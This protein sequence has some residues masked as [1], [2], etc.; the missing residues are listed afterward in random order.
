MARL[1]VNKSKITGGFWQ[2]WQRTNAENAIFHQWE[3]LEAS[4]CIDNFRI[5]AK[6]KA[7]FRQGWYFADSDAYKWLEAASAV[8]PGYPNPR[9]SKRVEAFISLIQC[10]QD[11]DGYLYTYNQIHFPGTRWVNLQIEH[12]LYCH[13]HLIEA[14]VTHAECL[15]EDALLAVSRK[16]AD[17]IAAD[18]MDKG[19]RWT[20]GHEEIEIALLRLYEATGKPEYLEMGRAFIERRG[21]M[22]CFAPAMLRNFINNNRRVGRVEGEKAAYQEA[23]PDQRV[24]PLPP[25]NEAKQPSGIG[26]RFMWNALSGKL[27]QQHRPLERQT[28]PVGHAVRFAYLKTAAAMLDRI[29]GEPRYLPSL[30]AAWAHMTGR[31]MYLTGGIG[32]L[33]AIEGFG[34]DFELDPEFA[35]AETCAALG[36]LFWN[37][38]MSQLTGKAQYSDL[39]EWQLYNAALVGMGLDGKS[40]FYNNPLVARGGIQRRDWYEVPC[41]P[42]NLSR[43]FARLG[44]AILNAQP[45]E[46]GIE[47]YI[48]SEH[49]L[50]GLGLS[51]S[52]ESGFP[53]HGQVVLQIQKAP[54]DPLTLK[55]RRP[56][57]AADLRIDLN[58][59][60]VKRI[61]QAPPETLDP[62]RASWI[63][64]RRGWETGDRL[65]L[66]FA[67]PVRVLKTDARVKATRGK[68]ALACGPLVYCLESVDRPGLDLFNVR[69]N[70]SSLK[71]HFD[72][73]LL[74]G[75]QVIEG[76]TV[77]GEKVRFIP[78][79]LWGNRGRSSM[80]VFVEIGEA[81]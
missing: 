25:G 61:Q 47:Q 17:R 15:G 73:D 35:Y 28:K 32:S 54:S 81:F 4:G 27:F 72:P 57:W 23:H 2:G 50:E 10:A 6:G 59:E 31:K 49:V 21:R 43:T 34:R 36:S 68:A 79:H 41:C 38:E 48:S 3:Q 70:P 16:A 19:P 71:A 67:M 76:E 13:G 52:I 39:F 80:T 7:G 33:P 20:P 63:Q 58:G 60:L 69:V 30:E 51:F 14:G 22:R 78:Y 46:V 65:T 37:R 18:F 45:G 62:L 66:D 9:L 56:S 64:I 24:P 40:Y 74:G 11:P 53:Y 12:E 5:L 75:V 8:L 77:G 26:L 42:S 1:K 44:E 29:T 55:L